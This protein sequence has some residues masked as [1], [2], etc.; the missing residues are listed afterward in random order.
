LGD[1]GSSSGSH[2]SGGS[3]GVPP[4]G[5]GGA[6]D[7]TG[8]SVIQGF[9]LDE[10]SGEAIVGASVDVYWRDGLGHSYWNSTYTDE[11]G[12]Y[13]ISVAGGRLLVVVSMDGFTRNSSGW[14]L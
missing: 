13:S 9:V 10:L 8:D 14:L 3:G 12:F 6:S 4:S 7:P 5:G 1:N 11:S 2:S